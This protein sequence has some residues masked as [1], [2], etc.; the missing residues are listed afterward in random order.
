MRIFLITTIAFLAISITCKAQWTLGGSN[1][2]PTIITNNVGIGT[3][4]PE[5]GQR[6][7]VNGFTSFGTQGSARIYMGTT[8]ATHAFIQARDNT[9]NQNLTFFGSAY[10]FT[11]GNVGVGIANPT[12]KFAVAPTSANNSI[13]QTIGVIQA[14]GATGFGGYIGQRVVSSNT[15]QGLAVSGTS[16]LTLNAQNYN[17]D[18]INGAI[19]PATDVN[20]SMRITA[21]GNVGIGT[22]SPDQKLTVNGTIHS[23]SVVVDVNIFPDY[24]FNKGYTLPLITDIKTYIDKN[25]HLPEMPSAAEVAK[26]GL[27]LGEMN[28]LLV[29]KVEELTLYLIEQQ[30]TNQSLQHQIDGLTKQI[31]K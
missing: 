29:K 14:S 9:V 31:K 24:V 12:S 11:T 1:I 18:F 17:I 10:N 7:D 23:K 4:T 19:T 8:D 30:K 16:S 21:T 20:L 13:D 15:R 28:K 27:N 22:A 6:L 26:D 3:T 2:Y 5:S 25:H